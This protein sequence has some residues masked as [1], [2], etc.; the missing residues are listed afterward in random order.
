M[1]ARRHVLLASAAI[2]AFAL[3]PALSACSDSAKNAQ[4]AASD[5]SSTAASSQEGSTH[6][7]TLIDV[8]TPEEFAE[9]HLKEARNIDFSAPDFAEKIGE[10]DKNAEYTLYC[11]SGRRAGEALDM[12]KAAGFTKVTNAG[13]LEEAAKALD[14]EIVKN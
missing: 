6:V 4:P 7:G 2:G 5:A 11:R 10:L 1:T 9:G 3:A 14:T 12:M 13:G 8:R